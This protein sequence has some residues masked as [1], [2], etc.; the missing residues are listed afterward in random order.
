MVLGVRNATTVPPTIRVEL[1]VTIYFGY[2]SKMLKKT[3]AFT[4][5]TIQDTLDV[6]IFEQIVLP[7]VHYTITISQKRH[8]GL[9]DSIGRKIRSRVF[10]RMHDVQK[11]LSKNPLKLA[12]FSLFYEEYTD[13]PHRVKELC[14][15]HN[16]GQPT[17]STYEHM[18]VTPI[19][20]ALATHSWHVE[21]RKKNELHETITL[22]H[23]DD[24]RRRLSYG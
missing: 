21:K 8:L 23:H 5:P 2:L 10:Y 16:K 19:L 1:F 14:L 17:R 20:D 6:T 9:A 3:R 11:A 12:S 18:I 24:H 22:S 7:N 13:G 4:R 15:I